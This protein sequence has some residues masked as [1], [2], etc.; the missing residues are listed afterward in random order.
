MATLTLKS[1]REIQTDIL[2]QLIAELGLNDVN[3]GS[4]ID[5]L[6]N[7]VAQEDFAQYVEMAKILRLTDL[8]AITG[9]DLDNK[10]FEFG[11]ERRVALKATGKVDI[12]R[13]AGFEKVSTT[14]YAGSPAAVEGDSVINV[15]DASSPLIGTS[16]TLILGRGT[17]NEEEVTYSAAPVNNTNFFTY[18]LDA[19]LTK[20]HAIEETVILKQGLDEGIIAGT[21]IRVPSTGTSAEILFTTNN[22]VTLLAGEDKVQ[23]VEV[24]A[25]NAG[26][27][28]NIAIKSIEGT[29]AFVTAP[30]LGAQ[31]ENNSKFTTGRDRETDDELRDR[32][33][34]SVQS[35]SRGVKEAI[36]T[37]LVGLVDEETAKRIVSVNIILP[38]DECG[39][40]L[41]YVDDGTGFEP[42][43]ESVGFE[44]VLRNSAGGE[45]RLQLDSFPIVK[46]QVENNIEE[47][48]N[49]SGVPLTLT[50]NVG[51]QSE[52]ITFVNS[53]FEFNESAS[54]EEIVRAINDRSL[55][56]E[57]R[58]SQTG[59]QVTINA[60]S[61]I[62]EDIQVT[63]GSAL[64]ILGFPTDLKQTLFLYVDDVL[65]SK[66][67]A[68]ALIDSGNQGPFNLLAVGAF[69]HTLTL[70]VDGK[71]ANPQTIT[72]QASDFLDQN[73]CTPAEMIAVMNQQM[74]GAVA[75][76]SDNN[77]RVRIVS[78]TK[79]SAGS[80]IQ[81]TG[82]TANDATNGLNFST[83]EA[84]GFDGEYTFNKELGTI[85][86]LNPL[87]ANVSVTSS[88][89][90]T[91][92]KLRASL[93]ENYAPNDTETLVISVDGGADQTVTFNATFV[94]GQSAQDTAD[95]INLQL[96]G[97]TA[98][99]REIGTQTFLEI[100]TN[101][102]ENG[103]IEIK[104]TSTANGVFGFTLDTEATS[105][106]PH[107]A[108]RVSGNSGPF[109]FREGD[110][111]VVVM[112]N[113]I[114]SST[115]TAIM[116][117]DGAATSVTDAQNFAILSFANIFE[118][119]G[120][121][122]DFDIAFTDGPTTVNVSAGV[123]T[124]SDQGGNTWRY[125][126]NAL[127]AGLA[128]IAIGDLAKIEGL[129]E[130]SNNGFFV[131]TAVSTAG[132]GYIEVT[133]D[134]GIAESGAAGDA[135]LSE[136]RTISAYNQI[137]GI[138]QTSAPFS[139]SPVIGNNAIVLPTTV[140][141]VVEYMNN[142]KI[143]SISL[144]ADITGVEGNTKVQIASK[145][146]GS[147]GYVQVTGGKAN[148]I[149]DF[150][151]DVYRG[152]QG[153]QRYTGL[154]KLAH[155]T[156]YGDDTDLVSFPGVGAAGIKFIFLAPTVNELSI[157]VNVTLAEGVSI[158]SLE[159]EI[160]SAITGYINNL[161]IG[162]DVIVEEI[163]CRVQQISGVRDVVLNSPTEN[164][165]IA[166]NELARTRD[167]LILVG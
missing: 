40:V 140:T 33:V 127:P 122:I 14:F 25:V 114:V 102:Y 152:L 110:S 94:G 8:Q 35:L 84:A 55:L 96:N 47:P 20:S 79:L 70:V 78:N 4:V 143:T 103:T 163:R 159:N 80:R 30:F 149:F 17:S 38:Q 164:I 75:E 125:E 88:S 104:S 136:K 87:A 157:N 29:E 60:K 34:S 13:P 139:A 36:R 27:S 28:G 167:S 49:M 113:D 11:L 86:F 153:Y 45:T 160:K 101:T 2:S 154:L 119:A 134:Q 5:I 24:T 54:A 43:F 66:D 162:D 106:R 147:D 142:V 129:T 73:A 144:K 105:Q 67:G 151:I 23:D 85:E 68:T 65:A 37:A 158:A 63:G 56:I 90:F 109:E 26:S 118:N 148:E 57:A 18:T 10:A 76:L 53:D 92:A 6:T 74:V 146:S 132:N 22:D 72:F 52:T 121:L 141:N 111:L 46:A 50:Y 166:D 51:T 83:T 138:I 12:L 61:D 133:N 135:T 59:K 41:I 107:Q 97:A 156:I 21:Q 42:D 71:T 89:L 7:A 137:G 165:I 117:F 62:N 99:A 115:F 44:E 39:P 150:S 81:I 161:G 155:R 31:A 100:N 15:N 1:Q 116:D 58:T 3:A 128:N 130:T 82:G 32:I 108:F 145:L 48:Y 77:S 98:I 64:S 126:F 9:S 19:P 69:P 16:G 93:S 131:I 123:E 112:D 124:I 95:F 120:E 91:R